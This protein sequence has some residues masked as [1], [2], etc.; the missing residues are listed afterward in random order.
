MDPFAGSGTT[1]MVAEENGREGIGIE[2]NPEY[3]KLIE[4]RLSQIQPKLF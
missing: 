2:L 4:E 1:M 3:V